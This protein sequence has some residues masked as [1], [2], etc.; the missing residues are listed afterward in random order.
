[1]QRGLLVLVDVAAEGRELVLFAG[2]GLPRPQEELLRVGAD[3]RAGARGDQ[4]F[5][6][7]PIFS[8]EAQTWTRMGRTFEELQVLLLGPPSVCPGGAIRQILH[9]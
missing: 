5:N 8:V 9:F 6:F 2:A 1:M 4:L 7:L 3:L